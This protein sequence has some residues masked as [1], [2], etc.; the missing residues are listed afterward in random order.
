MILVSVIVIP[1]IDYLVKVTMFNQSLKHDR[2]II[3]KFMDKA[4]DKSLAYTSGDISYR[5]EMDPIN[6][7][8]LVIHVCTL[9]A[10]IMWYQ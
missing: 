3:K 9:S 4:Y 6:L 10:E 1:L 5:L 2:I 7:R 8:W